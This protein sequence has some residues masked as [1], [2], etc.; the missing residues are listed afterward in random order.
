MPYLRVYAQGLPT[1]QKRVIAQ[2]LIEITLRTFKLNDQQRY[3]TSIQ[4]ITLPPLS[5]VDEPAAAVPRESDFTLEVIGHNLTEEK[6][7][8]FARE[9]TAM[10]AHVAPKKPRNRIARALGMKTKQLPQ[11]CLQFNELSPAVSDPFVMESQQ[12]AA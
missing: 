5:G 8:A 10:L 9:A 11:I 4:F 3:Q 7:R 12:Y 2:Q 6:K 1:E